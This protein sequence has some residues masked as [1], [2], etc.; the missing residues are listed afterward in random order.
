MPLV[1][2][3]GLRFMALCRDDDGAGA[4]QFGEV[5]GVDGADAAEAADGLDEFFGRE[6]AVVHV[7]DG[8]GRQVRGG[9]EEFF[10]VAEVLAARPGPPAEA[11]FAGLLEVV[12][13]ISVAAH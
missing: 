9:V 10:D 2:V 12:P 5:F 1:T 4:G 8:P 13:E 6:V 3:Y 11:A 7:R